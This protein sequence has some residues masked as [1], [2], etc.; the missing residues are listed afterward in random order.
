MGCIARV[1]TLFIYLN[2]MC[3]FLFSFAAN[4]WIS[5]L[6]PLTGGSAAV[7]SLSRAVKAVPEL[8]IDVPAESVPAATSPAAVAAS[9]APAGAPP[10]SSSSPTEA[11]P[12][13]APAPLATVAPRPRAL[14]TASA[15]TRGFLWKRGR[16]NPAPQYRYFIASTRDR[17]MSYHDKRDSPAKGVIDLAQVTR[18]NVAAPGQYSGMHNTH[19]MEL[20]TPS[21][22]WVLS[23]EDQNTLDGWLVTLRRCQLPI[24]R[25]DVNHVA[26]ADVVVTV[27]A[28]DGAGVGAGAGAGVPVAVPVG[29]G[30]P[31]NPGELWRGS[32]WKAG[33]L[34]S[35]FRR[36]L[37]VLKRGADARSTVLEYFDES[38]AR[39]KGTITFTADAPSKL[40]RVPAHTFDSEFHH[41]ALALQHG[42][43]NRVYQL[44]CESEATLQSCCQAFTRAPGVRVLVTTG[45][46]AAIMKQEAEDEE[47]KFQD[48]PARRLCTGATA[49]RPVIR[50]P[51]ILLAASLSR[52]E[53]YLQKAGAGAAPFRR[54]VAHVHGGWLK[55]ELAG[56]LLTF[57]LTSEVRWVPA[58]HAVPG[59]VTHRHCLSFASVGADG[60]RT[61]YTMAMPQPK[62]EEWARVV[63]LTLPPCPSCAGRL[64]VDY[65]V[66]LLLLALTLVLGGASMGSTWYDLD[67]VAPS[68]QLLHVRGLNSG[69]AWAA[70]KPTLALLVFALLVSVVETALM[71]TRVVLLGDSFVVPWWLSWTLLMHLHAFI[72]A[73]LLSAVIVYA[74]VSGTGRYGHRPDGHF[75]FG[76]A[77]AIVDLIF[78][79]SVGVVMYVFREPPRRHDEPS[80]VGMVGAVVAASLGS[81]HDAGRVTTGVVAEAQR[82]ALRYTQ[83]A[84]LR[85]FKYVPWVLTSAT[86]VPLMSVW[87]EADDHV[88]YTLR[89]AGAR[90]GS[91]SDTTANPV[92]K[93]AGDPAFA[94]MFFALAT[95]AAAGTMVLMRLN[96]CQNQPATM[97]MTLKQLRWAAAVTVA[98]SLCTVLAWAAYA[99]VIAAGAAEP[100]A[101]A[102][103]WGL[104]LTCTVI[105]AAAAYILF[106]MPRYV[107]KHDGVPCGT[108]ARRGP[109]AV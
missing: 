85:A 39:Q 103:G 46:V 14:R 98:A 17:Q 65:V 73:L 32:M 67:G 37:F 36:R 96:R 83:S 31:N 105:T 63:G 87:W 38:N 35:A 44:C 48:G 70:G 88:S 60:T 24:H 19:V 97:V 27:E 92:Y 78:H 4:V 8:A 94:M 64:R 101:L 42:P 49:V 1:D 95:T 72:V 71:M 99:G 61:V 25:S 29:A 54:A 66:V 40:G 109:T 79:V 89:L 108:A 55:V 18:V 50:R 104:A 59:Y 84:L 47:R 41:F 91:P 62:Q 33:K 3:S 22:K 34:N 11:A 45:S 82:G 100:G 43:S 2:P 10:T 76:F 80:D 51:D 56:C 57:S 93:R 58:P 15:I 7:A 20:D 12:P 5:T 30:T 6:Q 106:R 74:A 16:L 13:E 107:C 90:L 68:V 23:A 69:W 9:P 77:A 53:V 28:G 21:R 81:A 86:L 75:S 26:V 52:T 102:V